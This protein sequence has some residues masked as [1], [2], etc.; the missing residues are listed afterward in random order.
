MEHEKL[1]NQIGVE[2]E[3]GSNLYTNKR[4]ENSSWA[5]EIFN[6]SPLR[7]TVR[8]SSGIP[9]PPPLFDGPFL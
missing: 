9:L 7:S 8:H 2:L 5:K 4:R 6:L 1:S 3:A